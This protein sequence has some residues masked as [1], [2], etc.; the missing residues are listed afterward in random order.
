MLPATVRLPVTV[1]APVT[2]NPPEVMFSDAA[3]NCPLLGL[4]DK[5]LL[6]VAIYAD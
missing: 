2:V 4:N 6:L 3:V 1:L 5:L